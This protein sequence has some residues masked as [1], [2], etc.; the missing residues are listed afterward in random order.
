MEKGFVNPKDAVKSYHY[1][2][3]SFKS[4]LRYQV[5]KDH[6]TIVAKE[7]IAYVLGGILLL[8]ALAAIAYLTLQSMGLI[9]LTWMIPVAAIGISVGAG[10]GGA[11]VLVAANPRAQNGIR[12]KF[13]SLFSKDKKRSDSPLFKSLQIEPHEP[14]ELVI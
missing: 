11:G 12:D 8:L 3:E 6:P 9:H 2:S 7:V 10:V 14:N 13:Y 5:L 4:L 1:A